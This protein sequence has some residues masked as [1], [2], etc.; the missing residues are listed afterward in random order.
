MSAPLIAPSKTARP[1]TCRRRCVG[2]PLFNRPLSYS[3]NGLKIHQRKTMYAC[4]N[5]HNQATP[6]AR[7]FAS[8]S[9]E[10]HPPPKALMELN[11]AEMSCEI[12]SVTTRSHT[13]AL[14]LKPESMDFVFFVPSLIKISLPSSLGRKCI[15]TTDKKA[16]HERLFPRVGTKRPKMPTLG[17]RIASDNG[18]NKKTSD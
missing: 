9:H 4:Q 14:H 7:Y 16:M 8:Y 18:T 6:G 15:L 12:H 10:N 13:P 11:F 2:P 17:T 5:C 3:Y 1:F